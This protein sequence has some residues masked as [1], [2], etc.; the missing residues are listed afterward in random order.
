MRTLRG[1]LEGKVTGV[2]P[3]Y[4]ARETVADANVSARTCDGLVAETIVVH[5]GS[6]DEPLQVLRPLAESGTNT[7]FEGLNRGGCAARNRGLAVAKAP[8]VAFL[9]ADD[10]L[11]EPI[12]S[13][14]VEAAQSNDADLVFSKAEIRFS[15]NRSSDIKQPFG[16][17]HETE[18]D[19]VANG[20][21]GIWVTP[22]AVLWK[23]K[24][25]SG[26][27]GWYEDLHVGHDGEVI[28][29]AM[30][31]GAKVTPNEIGR[32]IYNRGIEGSVSLSGGVTREKPAQHTR[33]KSKRCEAAREKDW[34]DNLTRNYAAIYFLVRKVFMESFLDLGRRILNVLREYRHH[35]HHGSKLHV[36]TA[37]LIGLERRSR[38]FE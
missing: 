19:A 36:Q 32:A 15:D 18:R 31:T 37:C 9:D 7:L 10:L 23:R 3:C 12:L 25:L 35:D 34:D 8:H 14:A 20:F 26:M 2:I 38:F 27:G 22:S 13:G 17:P 1:D 24:F 33:R 30:L 21:D 4:N 16:L 28:L 6:T 5:D 29:R 11:E